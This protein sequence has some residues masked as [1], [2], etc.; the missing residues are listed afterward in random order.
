[1]T[2]KEIGERVK[3]RR[4][5]LDLTQAQ[6]GE[7]AGLKGRDQTWG[8]L[9]RGEQTSYD[10]RTL[11]GV[12]RV[13]GWTLDSFE[14]MLNGHEPRLADAPPPD[15]WEDHEAR[16]VRLEGLAGIAPDLLAR[17]ARA[18][19]RVH[20]EVAGAAGAAPPRRRRGGRR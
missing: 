6:A 9:E 19:Q 18:R 2:W 7:Q 16:I 1:M 17:E 8:K 13:L 20:G 15:L 11:A 12:C 10:P 3:R 4:V 5:Q 14:L